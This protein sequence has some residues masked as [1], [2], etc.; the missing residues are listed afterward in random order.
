METTKTNFNYIDDLASYALTF[1]KKSKRQDDSEFWH[2]IDS[3]PQWL[4][5]L[6]Y[7]AHDRMLPNDFVYSVIV[8]ALEDISRNGNSESFL[9]ASIY[10]SELRKWL[11]DCGSVAEGFCEYGL[12]DGTIDLESATMN[13]ILT[14][15]QYNH[16]NSI[17]NSV[18][19]SLEQ[20]LRKE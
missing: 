13:D 6:C 10:N 15:G 3:R 20:Q 8:D 7:E 11:W 1:F 2:C 9:E 19:H 16:K 14:I 17:L 5:D 4:Q 12:K 18:R